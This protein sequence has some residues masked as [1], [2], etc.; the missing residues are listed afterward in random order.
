VERKGKW[1]LDEDARLMEGVKLYTEKKPSQIAAFVGTRSSGQ[2]RD[3]LKQLR[4]IDSRE[5]VSHSLPLPPPSVAAPSADAAIST[6]A[7][8]AAAAAATI[9]DPETPAEA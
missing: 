3:R 7:A 9:A 2:V 1:T 6:A 8:A 5:V 4:K